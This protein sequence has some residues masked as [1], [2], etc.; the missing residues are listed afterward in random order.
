[1]NKVIN[2][3]AEFNRA[4]LDTDAYDGSELEEMGYTFTRNFYDEMN[5]EIE[6]EDACT[7][8]YYV[9]YEAGVF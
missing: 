1:M 9:M 6:Y 4:L 5:D 7:Y 3:V 8:N 2:S